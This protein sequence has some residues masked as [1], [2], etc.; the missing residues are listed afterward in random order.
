MES[1]R[2]PNHICRLKLKLGVEV[3]CV[4]DG[5]NEYDIEIDL[6]MNQLHSMVDRYGI[7]K[8]T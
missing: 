7:F 4:A 5:V 6:S 8:S 2:I 1:P 3:D